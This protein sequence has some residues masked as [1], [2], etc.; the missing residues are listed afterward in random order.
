MTT[1]VQDNAASSDGA[2]VTVGGVV[3][4]SFTGV[5]AGDVTTLALPLGTTSFTLDHLGTDGWYVCGVSV[6][7][8]AVSESDGG[9]AISYFAL[10]NPCDGTYSDA[11]YV[12]LTLY[13]LAEPPPMLLRTFTCTQSTAD[14]ADGFEVRVGG[15]LVGVSVVNIDMDA[16]DVTT[17]ELPHDTTAFTLDHLGSDGW[18]CCGIQVME[19]DESAGDWNLYAVSETDGGAAINYFNMDN[20]VSGTYTAPS[21]DSIDLYVLDAADARAAVHHV[22]RGRRGPRRHELRL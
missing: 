20:P 22:R 5:S 1:C 21:Y 6:D 19:W 11:C 8:N 2:S 15:T 18:Y 4:G 16:G 17:V 14:T 9:A 10:D 13:V 3:V 7:G 12:S